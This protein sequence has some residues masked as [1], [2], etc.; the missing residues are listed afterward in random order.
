MLF[1]SSSSVPSAPIADNGGDGG[2]DESSDNPDD[3]C[4][5]PAQLDFIEQVSQSWYLWFDE[6]AEVD[7]ADYTDPAVYLD[8]LVAPLAAD[9]RD[10][11]FSY[12]TSITADEAR[13]TSG[14]YIGFGFRYTITA[15][16]QFVM[17]DVFEGSPAY[18]AG[19]RRGWELLAIDLGTGFETMAALRDRG[20]T[21]EEIFGANEIGTERLFRLGKAD[22]LLEAVVAKVELDPPALAGKPLVIR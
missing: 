5:V 4:G 2:S 13:F 18:E 22:T 8:A 10:P 7:K 3:S 17:I 19:F 12:L 15:A 1:R 14:A 16:N 20:A 6:L 11:G 9:L 21:S